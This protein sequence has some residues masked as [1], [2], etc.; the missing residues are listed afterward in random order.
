MRISASVV[1]PVYRPCS[2]HASSPTSSN[3]LLVCISR[4]LGCFFLLLFF[5]FGR[6]M[7]PCVDITRKKLSGG[8][9]TLRLG[10][11]SNICRRSSFH[12]MEPINGAHRTA[13]KKWCFTPEWE[14]CPSVTDSLSLRQD[15]SGGLQKSQVLLFTRSNKRVSQIRP[16]GPREAV[17]NV[18]VWE[19][20]TTLLD[21]DISLR[22]KLQISNLT[23]A[24]KMYF[25]LRDE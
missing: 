13:S 15:K 3:A 8:Q 23:V 19:K 21:G 20:K 24:L 18:S 2:F 25:L 1:Y 10:G 11:T 7:Y 22:R 14:P 17:R 12:C 9:I 4:W 5:F 6:L 16:I